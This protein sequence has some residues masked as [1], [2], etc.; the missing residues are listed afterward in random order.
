MSYF[1]DVI[2]PL[3]LKRTYT[4]AITPA[5][6]NFLNLGVR[7]VVPFGKRKTYTGL[8]SKI[9][10]LAPEA[11]EAKNIIQILD[12]SPVVSGEQMQ[13]WTW[14]SKYYLCSLGEVFLAALPSL[15]RLE[16]SQQV[17]WIGQ[18]DFDASQLSD[19][20][21]L[22]YEAL[23]T[24]SSLPLERLIEIVGAKK[25]FKEIDALLELKLV[26]L[27]D[28]VYDKYKDKLVAHIQIASGFDSQEKRPEIMELIQRSE[29]QR[30]AVM[31]YFSLSARDG[32][33]VDLKH[34]IETSGVSRAVIKAL[35]DKGVFERL[36]LKQDRVQFLNT[37]EE[38][39]ALS[40]AQLEA[41]T[42]IEQSFQKK[43]VCLFM[44]V[45]G[46]GKTHVYGHLIKEAIAQGKQVL[47]LLPE[48]GL[49]TQ[50]IARLEHY[51]GAD[52]LVYHSKY[53][54]Q[55]RMEVWHK[56]QAE[57][58]KGRLILATRSGIFLPFS[59]LS[60]I[61]VDEEHESS[62]KQQDPSPRFQARDSAIVLGAIHKA[63]VLLGSAT[64][65]IESSFNVVLEK[66]A[67]VGLTKRFGT[68]I[69]P[70]I[71]L[72]D[73]KDKHHKKRMTGH[74]SDTLLKQMQETLK[75]GRQIILFQNRRGYAPVVECNT[76]GH[77][78]HCPNCDVSL[79]FHKYA[80]ELRC[81]YCF[82]KEPVPQTCGACGSSE[83]DTKGFGTEQIAKEIAEL[84]PEQKV[85]RMDLDATR[86]KNAFEEI[87]TDFEKGLTQIL[88]GTQMLSKGLDFENVGLVGVVSADAMLNFPDFR[89][90]EKA[91]QLL[92]QVSGR[93]G[94]SAIRGKV[95]IQ[96]FNPYHQ[97]LQQVSRY[98]YKAMYKEQLEERY[99]F[100]YPP[101]YKLIKFT[102]K[103]K[104]QNRVNAACNWYFQSL[105]NAF[106]DL[107]LGPTIPSIARVRN[108]YIR[109]VSLKIPKKQS[110]KSV[111]EYIEK[112]NMHFEAVADFRSV[113]FTVDV[114]PS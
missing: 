66:F 72:I 58:E 20:S 57:P 6:F 85:A 45:T 28:K 75:E 51:F 30:M 68:A 24:A 47:Y 2:L 65:S 12:D 67:F 78:P 15:F 71:Q 93:A 52:M 59:N 100:K 60:L 16:S 29:K 5:E 95:M 92:T 25:I 114:D 19:T 56:L 33:L 44:G 4:Y 46:S 8:V 26:A 99:Q 42:K 89:A 9:H 73:L 31:S 80:Q 7:V 112:I 35:V 103:H 84:F 109:H 10:Q 98:D 63:K 50:I 86:R 1:V 55:E 106:G 111:K 54:A 27:E 87:I 77:S 90:H 107:V 36:D 17:A 91:Y 83:I 49:T 34:L 64:P 40:P 69:S 21:Y 41:K 22:I 3:P 37:N 82:Y 48:I 102:F 74:F 43:E 101:Y 97:I 61:I 96:T 105:E 62:Y 76:C 39:G 53:N 104:D 14:M 79:T 38:L 13:F 70:E 18:D 81:H 113:R 108:K 88:V 110:L 94:R 11:Y 32:K 23:Q